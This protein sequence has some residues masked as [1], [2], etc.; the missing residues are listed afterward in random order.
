MGLLGMTGFGFGEIS[1][2]DFS[3]RTEIR[4][5][6]SKG[7]DVSIKGSLPFA[8]WES[9][10]RKDILSSG[11]HRGHVRVDVYM[12]V[13][14]AQ[15]TIEFNKSF[16]NSLLK[17]L[18][19]EG[20]EISV[21]LSDLVSLS[22][23]NNVLYIEM[24]EDK[25]LLR[26]TREA[27]SMAIE[28]LN[29]QRRAEGKQMERLIKG[30]EKKME[31]LFHKLAR[32]ISFLD[33]KGVFEDLPTKGK[34][35]FEELNR[36][37]MNMGLFKKVMLDDGP[38]G[39]ELDFISQEILREANTFLAKIVDARATKYALGIKVAADRMREVLQNVE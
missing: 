19:K 24:K 39:K 31:A 33:K 18:E 35:V 14:N 37:E 11:I 15:Y 17:G 1:C 8:S 34:D 20:L 29:K 27:L 6:N 36:L 2:P 16:I 3:V 9:I 7:L 10:I 28:R 13:R 5:W 38:K 22:N 32:R 23:I 30:Q 25:R 12:K 21:S 26:A 4:S